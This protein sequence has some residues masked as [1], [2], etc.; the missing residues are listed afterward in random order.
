LGAWRAIGNR[1]KPPLSLMQLEELP[2]CYQTDEPFEP[3]EIDHAIEGRAQHRRNV[4][5]YNGGLSEEQWAMVR[6]VGCRDCML[7]RMLGC[8]GR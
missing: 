6:L 7:I 4:V 8:G 1:G 3:K 5:N 2:E